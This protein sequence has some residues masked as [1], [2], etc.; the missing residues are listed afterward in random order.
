M[1]AVHMGDE[2]SRQRVWRRPRLRQADDRASPGVELERDAA[3][4]NQRAGAGAAA[5][6]RR[7]GNAGAGEYDGRG[8]IGHCCLFTSTQ[9]AGLA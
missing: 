8:K 3:M 7:V 5:A 1:V 6:R 4:T 2:L 9:I